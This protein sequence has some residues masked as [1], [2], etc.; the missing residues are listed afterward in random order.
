MSEGGEGRRAD[1]VIQW[2][3]LIRG[4]THQSCKTE[5]A[6]VQANFKEQYPAR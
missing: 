3:L 5:T 4:S 6:T 2:P 1:L